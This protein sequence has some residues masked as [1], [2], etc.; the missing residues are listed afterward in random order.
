[1]ANAG[2]L[3]AE[4]TDD[5]E[6]EYPHHSLDPAPRLVLGSCSQHGAEGHRPGFEVFKQ[7]CKLYPCLTSFVV[8]LSVLSALIVL[9]CIGVLAGVQT[10]DARSGQIKTNSQLACI[11]LIH[12][13]IYSGQELLSC[14][15]FI[16][17]D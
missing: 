13:I 5:E 10:L 9:V 8:I 16:V 2:Q 3:H 11:K 7:K 4:C 6:V 14:S 15:L 1:M 12:K 17:H